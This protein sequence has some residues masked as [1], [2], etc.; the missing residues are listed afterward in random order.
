V[1]DAIKPPRCRW[2]AAEGRPGAFVL[3]DGFYFCEHDTCAARQL[4]HADHMLFD[5]PE[6]PLVSVPTPAQV[7]LR[8]ANTPNVL[9]GSG[10]GVAKSTGLRRDAYHW[11]RTIPGYTVLLMRRTFP[12]LDETHLLHMAREAPKFGAAYKPGEKRMVWSNES[13]IKAGHCQDP[14]DYMKMQSREYDHI[15]FDEGTTFERSQML[16][17]S[18]RARSTNPKVRE[19]GGEYVRIGSNPGGPGHMFLREFFIDKNPDPD[20]FPDYMPEDY[21]FMP[22]LLQDNPYLAPSYLRRLLQLE[23][24]RRNQ[25][26]DGDWSTFVGQ[27][28]EMFNPAIHVVNG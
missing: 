22:G 2:C 7:E 3:R 26:I 14:K 12:E 16:E 24:G 15:I 10:A 23:P 25:L 9:W 28:F 20:E 11:C 4:A 6:S 5:D 1:T 21:A 8:E 19:R 27:H 18:S 17:I 13:S